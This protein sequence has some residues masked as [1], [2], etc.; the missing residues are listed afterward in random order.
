MSRGRVPSL[1]SVNTGRPKRTIAKRKSSCKRCKKEL[2]SGEI[3]AEIPKH[4]GY[5]SYKR[6][7]LNCFTDILEKT[8]SELD[9]IELEIC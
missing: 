4:A 5:K 2:I 8:R 6:Y 7:C 9:E 1:L 3:C